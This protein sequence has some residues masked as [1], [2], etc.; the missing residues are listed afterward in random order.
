MPQAVSFGQITITDLTD[1]GTLSV[2]PTANQPLNVIYDPDQN[3]YTP[4]WST[5]NL[6][7]TP[8]IYY[9]GRQLVSGTDV[10][11]T[12]TWK[13]QEGS[14]T[15]VNISTGESV[16]AGVLTVSANKF[17][18]SIS[19]VS[20]IVEI[21]YV[22]PESN[23]TL[24]AAGKITFSLVKQASI[25]KTASIT[26][27]T[28]FK[29]NSAQTIVG[30]SSITLNGTVTGSISISQWQYQ[31]SSGEWV[32]YPN[33]GTG[34][35]LTVNDTDATFV[36]NKCLIKL[37]TSDN[38]IYDLH[39]ITKLYDGAN[40]TSTIGAVLTNEDQMLPAG[41]DGTITSYDGAQTQLVIYRGSTVDTAN[42]NIALSSTGT[43][44]YQVSSDG[45][46]WKASGTT[47]DHWTYVKVTAMT[48]DTAS[49]TF[50]AS[51]TGETT[52]VK[53]F[54]IVKVKTG[55]DGH[56][57]VIYSIEP[58][59]LSVNKSFP[60]GVT[61]YTPSSIVVNAYQK[62][63]ANARTAYSGRIRIRNGGASGTAIYSSGSN[64][65]SHTVTS[66]EIASA[67][68][69]YM[70]VQ[71]YEKGGFNTV[72]DTQTIVITSDGAAGDSSIAAVL[73]N[74]SQVL[75]ANSGGAVTSYDGAQTQLLI[76]RG[77]A[78][79]TDSWS[80]ALSTTGTLTYQ[81]SSDGSTWKSSSTTG[82]HWSY[83]KVTALTSD[84]ASITFTASKTGESNLVKTFSVTKAKAGAD[85]DD[86]IIY[87]IEPLAVSVNKNISGAF[88]PST[89]V[90]NAYQKTGANAR[91]AYSGYIRI[92]SGGSS[93]TIIRSSS[94]AEST[95]T[96]TSA[97]ITSAASA[98]YMTVQL[99]SDSGFS[100]LLDSQ[101]IVI[102]SDGSPSLNVILGNQADVIPCTSA[103][104][105]IAQTT[106][107]IPFSAY[108]GTS[109]IGA[110]V[111][112]LPTILGV[113]PSASASPPTYVPA[114][115]SADG[116][117][118]YTI[119]ANTSVGDAS[120]DIP[121]TF[122]VDGKTVTMYYRY[123]RSTAATNGDSAV[124]LQ[125]LTPKGTVFANSSTTD[126]LT[127]QGKMY[128]GAQVVTP[129]SWVWAKY[130][131]SGYTDITDQAS[132][133]TGQGTDTLTIYP[134]DVDGFSSYRLTATYKSVSYEQYASIIDKTDPLQVEVLSS[135]G[136]QI[137]NG[138]GAG[139]FY[140]IVYRNGTE[141][142]PIKSTRFLEAAPNA[143][144]SGDYYY[145]IDKTNKTVTLK[146]F[147]GTSWANAPTSDKPTGLYEWTHLDKNG[148]SFSPCPSTGG[149]SDANRGKV[150]YVDGTL[151][152]KKMI[153]TV[154][155]TI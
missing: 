148:A 125:M 42:W 115:T 12:V 15:P 61:T 94:S 58:V 136:D 54:S 18:A 145:H 36:N 28:I 126:T 23:V 127:I 138:T 133:H 123:T 74:E 38:T 5:S 55:A 91:T 44:T 154:E 60:D 150:I 117:L 146:K 111:P 1:V 11:L 86:P 96:I 20:Y 45:T 108:K 13:R 82:S 29:Y 34:S 118:V 97:N 63:G 3:L 100:N 56:D 68:T 53:T 124:I 109:R 14:S 43:L 89:I 129:T 67:S 151:F 83:V 35:T 47:G 106:I 153:S 27:D 24:T 37:A 50:T 149:A 41:A 121:I 65:S 4:N 120:K 62:T 75:P 110:T 77:S 21:S 49:I 40:G 79:E 9:A 114:S 107:T 85:G 7:V 76:Y 98:G 10:G 25:A 2:Y 147:N 26:G 135:I 131:G 101:T 39:T 78:V 8:I 134:V 155:V 152:D 99:Y 141:I 32:Q 17:S 113:T 19:M 119:P 143:A 59:A 70:T 22:E 81:V 128:Y 104:K 46:T 72:L 52:L 66:Q 132:V 69:G 140:V 6:V 57:P 102:T 130:T 139:A 80:I 92:R 116:K 73:T 71:L 105:T 33:S 122:S 95:Y 31:N 84:T 64:E 48:T 142:D 88:T 137:I 90:V 51:K 103:N 93:G 16:S 30:A 112:N 87:T 144:S